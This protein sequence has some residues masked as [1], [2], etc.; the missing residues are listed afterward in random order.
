MTRTATCR[1]GAVAAAC[2]GDPI[3]VSVCHCHDCQRRSGS[4][5][6][7]QVRFPASQVAI[8]GALSTYSVVGDSG[9]CATF[10]FCP[11][12]GGTIAYAVRSMPDIVAIPLGAF[13][14]R[15]AFPPPEYS[16][17]EN[18]KHHWVSV[19]APCL[20]PDDDPEDQTP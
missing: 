4:A 9:D 12:C 11:V 17:Y 2:S 15:D 16:V 13:A 18:R 5:F 19:D 8:T 7:A 14:D 6:A 20:D 10:R 1:C 3:R